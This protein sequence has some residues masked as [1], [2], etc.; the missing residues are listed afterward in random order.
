MKIQSYVAGFSVVILLG[1]QT[2][3]TQASIVLTSSD[4]SATGL[5]HYYSVNAYCFDEFSLNFANSTAHLAN[6]THVS[7]TLSAPAGQMFAVG[8]PPATSQSSYLEF[9]VSFGH[10]VFGGPYATVSN[11]SLAFT[12]VNG[13]APSDPPYYTDMLIPKTTGNQMMSDMYVA[14]TS[15]FSFTDVNFSFDYNNSGITDAPMGDFYSGTLQYAHELSTDAPDPG[16]LLTLTAVPEPASSGLMAVA[17]LAA[18]VAYRR[19]ERR[20][21]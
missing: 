15:G 13:T 5:T 20:K 7:I 6:D 8:T 14:V 10:Y 11:P 21:G 9:F 18:R 16:T 17:L 3:N 4:P 19:A 2:F 1:L 12:V